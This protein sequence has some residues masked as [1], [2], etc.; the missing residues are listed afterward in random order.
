MRSVIIE[1][2]GVF[3]G[4]NVIG[5]K[6]QKITKKDLRFSLGLLK[7]LIANQSF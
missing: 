6:M 7:A 4:M 2:C 5:K 1:F 3:L